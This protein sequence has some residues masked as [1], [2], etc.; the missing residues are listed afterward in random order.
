[1]E[2][3]QLKG[4]TNFLNM[5]PA[6][7]SAVNVI[8]QDSKMFGEHAHISTCIGLMDPGNLDCLRFRAAS[9]DCRDHVVGQKL[10]SYNK[11][12]CGCVQQMHDS[13]VHTHLGTYVYIPM[14]SSNTIIE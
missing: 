3:I 6:L 14:Q 10:Y 12:V 9:E 2:K 7:Y 11:Q 8:Q 1:M 5:D 4:K 13:L